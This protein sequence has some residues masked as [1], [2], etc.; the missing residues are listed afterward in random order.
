VLETIARVANRRRHVVRAICWIAAASLTV[1]SLPA[2]AGGA[3]TPWELDALSSAIHDNASGGSDGAVAI[4]PT[5]NT[6]VDKAGQ[7]LSASA[8][9]WLPRSQFTGGL[10]EGDH[11]WFES[12]ALTPLDRSAT[13]AFFLQGDLNRSFDG[14]DSRLDGGAGLGIR[15]LFGDGLWLAGVNAFL[16]DGWS[17][18]LARGSFGGRLDSGPF[19]VSFNFYQPYQGIDSGMLGGL[20]GTGYDLSTR[21]QLPFVPTA[22]ASFETT[23]WNA[24]GGGTPQ[25]SHQAGLRFSPFPFL[26]LDGRVSRNQDDIQDYA[27]ELHL[28]LKLD[29]SFRVSDLPLIDSQP[30]RFTSMLSHLIDMVDRSETPTQLAAE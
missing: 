8:P 16:D 15:H 26:D 23:T 24:D 7:R 5:F 14:T 18:S 6:F 13:D 2:W 11:P 19:G 9:A 3:P 28:T 1:A 17:D 25:Y 29:G 20:S 27:V 30:F 12:R 21:I 22:S 4:L 10:D